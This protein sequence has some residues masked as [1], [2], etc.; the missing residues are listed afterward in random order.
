MRLQS[1][2][3]WEIRIPKIP[4][5]ELSAKGKEHQVSH[6]ISPLQ[7]NRLR[8][9]TERGWGESARKL[10]S[11]I[12]PMYAYGEGVRACW[13]GYRRVVNARLFITK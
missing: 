6:L 11:L 4:L 9:E 8:G 12:A 5:R 13:E 10:A 1:E 7:I 3:A 2:E